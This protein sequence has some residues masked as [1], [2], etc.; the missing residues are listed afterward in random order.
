MRG[1]TSGTTDGEGGCWWTLEAIDEERLEVDVEES[2]D[3]ELSSE[4]SA[5]LSSD[6]SDAPRDF[7]SIFFKGCFA[8]LDDPSESLLDVPSDDVDD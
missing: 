2:V 6:P 1:V 5:E 4:L 3:E 7:F 8:S